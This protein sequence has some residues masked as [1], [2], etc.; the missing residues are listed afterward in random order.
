[1]SLYIK[2]HQLIASLAALLLALGCQPSG[3]VSTQDATSIGESSPDDGSQ[4]AA[5]PLVE[6]IS[7]PATVE[8][9]DIDPAD[10]PT[11]VALTAEDWPQFR[12]AM[13]D[14][15]VRGNTQLARAW[16]EGG[17]PIL[18]KAAV[19]QGYSAPS[20]VAG[21]IYLNDYDESNNEW[22]VRCLSLDTGDQHWIYRVPKRIRPNHS[23]T[24]S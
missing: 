9:A 21:R 19:G 10:L 17:P 20:I 23:I 14:G 11:P 3:P 2:W 22:L 6:A 13:R 15:I 5:K 16:P 18:W 7:A 24:R 4:Q 12:G 8:A 1:M